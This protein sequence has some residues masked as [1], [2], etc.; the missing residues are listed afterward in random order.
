MKL[1]VPE[2]KFEK[3]SNEAKKRHI[4]N[5]IIDDSGASPVPND[6]PPAAYVMAGIPG[7]GKTEFLDSIIEELEAEKQISKFV[8]IDLD[9]IVTIYPGYT[10]KTY[11]KYRSQGNNVLARCI[12]VLRNLRYNMM[13]DGTFSGTSGSSI[14]NVEKLLG[15]GYRVSMIYMYDEPENAWYYTKQREIETNR[16]IDKSSFINSCKNI[17]ANL[18]EVMLKFN[19]NDNFTLSVVKQKK[20]RDRNYEI[21]DSKEEIDKIVSKGYNIDKMKDILQ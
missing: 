11:A 1:N 13:I 19:C 8:R 6:L 9:Q 4:V 15:A 20:L 7:A 5:L 16:G 3:F 10:P 12:D 2:D 17:S 21:I 14:R 18:K